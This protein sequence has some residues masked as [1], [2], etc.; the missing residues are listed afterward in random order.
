AGGEAGGVRALQLLTGG[1]ER[2]MRLIGVA[3]L[4]E[5]GPQHVTQLMRL[6]PRELGAP[7]AG[8]ATAPA[9]TPA[10]KPAA[11]TR[12]RSSQ[13]RRGRA[14]PRPGPPAPSAT[15]PRPR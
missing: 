6:T 12:A 10:R 4:E 14:R 8:A 2:V 5:L 15:Q 3:S 11:R 13:H 7:E 9:R 1:I